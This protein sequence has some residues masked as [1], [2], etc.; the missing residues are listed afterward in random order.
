MENKMTTQTQE[1][2]TDTK[3]PW[4]KGFELTRINDI[5]TCFSRYNSF[6][7]SP[8]AQWNGP[9]IAD[10]LSKERLV[11][12]PGAGYIDT[13]VTKTSTDIVM[14]YDVV[15][16]KKLKGDRIINAIGLES[17]G[18][19]DTIVGAI[20]DIV[21]KD[22]TQSTWAYVFEEDDVQ[23]K[24]VE[25]AGFKKIGIKVTTF[26]E[27]YGIYF[28]DAVSA[29]TPREHPYVDPAE[30]LSLVK[31]NS[32][33]LSKL[34]DTI[35]EK[36]EK[37][38]VQY[39][40]HYSKHN[41]GKAW[42]AISLRGFSQDPSFIS[43]PACMGEAW[44]KEHANESYTLQ[45]TEMRS[46]FPEVEEVV[47]LLGL[48]T[49]ERIR[50]MRLAPGGGELTRH[51]D[52]VEPDAGV[53]DGTLM[54]I[55]LPIKTNPKVD[56]TVWDYRGKERTVNMKKGELWYLDIRKPHRAINGGNEERIHLVVDIGATD[57]LKSLLPDEV[58]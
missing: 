15:I 24:V 2:S 45:D 11:H 51:T 49:Q 40:N 48:G 47:K 1:S 35:A 5:K 9:K 41:K 26:S 19:V 13:H 4:Q 37:F 22:S 36:L 29:T 27:I 16:G 33:N 28:R 18:S 34:C 10:S 21:T 12:V 56:F 53:T 30:K 50:F 25:Q 54:R 32:P 44:N 43:K 31:L 3:K 7:F 39:A 58:E 17:G 23:R 46:L 20:R 38:D 6:A 52:Q 57:D 8:F 14:Y 42:S 55:H